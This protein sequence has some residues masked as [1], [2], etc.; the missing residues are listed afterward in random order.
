MHA[1]TII[2]VHSFLFFMFYV[3][4]FYKCLT[5]NYRGAFIFIFYVLCFV[6]SQ[7]FNAD[8]NI[9]NK[10]L[11]A[12]Q[13]HLPAIHFCCP[14]AITRGLEEF[15]TNI[16]LGL[17]RIW[18]QSTGYRIT[19][20]ACQPLELFRKTSGTAKLV[21]CVRV[22]WCLFLAWLLVHGISHSEY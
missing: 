6:F 20:V 14:K 3:L 13:C 11:L 5:H 2:V 8:I 12:G 4:C 15:V 18:V 16:D 19:K 1:P 22:Y 21:A 10:S 9:W 7:V 17:L